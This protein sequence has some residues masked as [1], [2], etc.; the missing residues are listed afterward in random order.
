[1]KKF[2]RHFEEYIAAAVF[3]VMLALTFANVIMRNFAA[4]ISFTEEITGY[5]N[6][7]VVGLFLSDFGA[8]VLSM[9]GRLIVFII[10]GLVFC[11]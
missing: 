3:I 5:S 2:F 6:F 4:A 9:S 7:N 8:V 1:M 10:L 11:F